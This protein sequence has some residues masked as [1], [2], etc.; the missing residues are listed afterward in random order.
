MEKFTLGQILDGMD[1]NQEVIPDHMYC[2]YCGL[3]LC[4][5]KTSHRLEEMF[6][7]ARTGPCYVDICDCKGV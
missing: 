4:D 5:S 3:L 2:D 6:N 1:G 7:R